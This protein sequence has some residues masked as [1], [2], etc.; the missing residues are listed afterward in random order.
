MVP[1]IGQTDSCKPQAA[2]VNLMIMPSFL[3]PVLKSSVTFCQLLVPLSAGG[4][5]TRTF[6][7]AASRMEI[8][9]R[10]PLFKSWVRKYPSK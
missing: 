6:S 9:G 4:E 8:D 3:G 10:L 1:K 7:V 5:L 2:R